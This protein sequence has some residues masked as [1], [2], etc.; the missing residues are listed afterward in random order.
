MAAL[1][2]SMFDVVEVAGGFDGITGVVTPSP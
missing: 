2:A 1:S